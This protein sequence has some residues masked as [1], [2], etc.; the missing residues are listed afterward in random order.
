MISASDL[1]LS[2]VLLTDC[3]LAAIVCLR[4]KHIPNLGKVYTT[5]PTVY[6]TQLHYY[7]VH[8][9]CGLPR[10]YPIILRAQGSPIS[11]NIGQLVTDKYLDHNEKYYWCT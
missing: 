1:Y 3:E 11:T 5:F 6:S 10:L 7:L 2:I 9:V 8:L 4:A